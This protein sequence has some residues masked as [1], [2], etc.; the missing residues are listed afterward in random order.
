LIVLP[1]DPKDEDMD[2]ILRVYVPDME[3]MK[4]WTP[5]RAEKII[6]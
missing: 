3:K 2:I 4:I 6:E 1:P 5:P